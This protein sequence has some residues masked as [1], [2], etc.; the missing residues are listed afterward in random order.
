MVWWRANH[1]VEGTVCLAVYAVYHGEVA[2]A[3]VGEGVVA[4]VSVNF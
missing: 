2:D 3:E 1:R 4:V